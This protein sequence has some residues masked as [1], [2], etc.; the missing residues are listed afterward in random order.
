MVNMFVYTLA[1][2]RGCI[3]TL[4]AQLR[5]SAESILP[6]QR[7]TSP[8]PSLKTGGEF[9]FIVFPISNNFVTVFQFLLVIVT[10]SFFSRNALV[11]LV[12][13]KPFG[14]WRYIALPMN[15]YSSPLVF[16]TSISSCG[17][18]FGTAER[19]VMQ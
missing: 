4:R 10:F 6:I 9:H 11:T 7:K 8:T 1:L 12:L 19:K 13:P 14:Q 5:R 2:G 16:R 15:V 17:M 3:S 18:F